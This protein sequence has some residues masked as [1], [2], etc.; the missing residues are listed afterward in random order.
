MHIERFAGAMMSVRQKMCG[1]PAELLL[2]E[3]DEKE[4][5]F[6]LNEIMAAGNFGH[7]RKGEALQRNSVKRFWVMAKHYPSEV[8]WMVPWKMWHKCWRAVKGSHR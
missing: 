6:L 2:C 7:Q 4:G 5:K 8:L 3:P 1:A